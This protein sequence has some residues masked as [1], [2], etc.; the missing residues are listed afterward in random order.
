MMSEATYPL[1]IPV[2]IKKGRSV[3]LN[4]W[5]ASTLAEKVDAVETAAEVFKKRAGQKTGDPL[6]EFLRNAP[7][8]LPAPEDKIR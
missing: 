8:V 1:E 5:I 3:S 2:S 4:Q 7:N 6:M